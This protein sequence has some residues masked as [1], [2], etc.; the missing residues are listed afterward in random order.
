MSKDNINKMTEKS[1]EMLKS[2]SNNEP[3][4]SEEFES[5]I[6]ALKKIVNSSPESRKEVGL[7]IQELIRTK[8][9][10]DLKIDLIQ[11]PVLQGRLSIGHR[12]KFKTIPLLKK[13]FL[14]LNEPIFITVYGFPLI[15]G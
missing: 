1:K 9:S 2:L 11:V 4:D 8:K 5:H 6:I 14:F 3:M 10:Y 7:L 15:F 13:P 12:P